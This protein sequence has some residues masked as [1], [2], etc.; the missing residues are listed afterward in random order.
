MI[1]KTPDII[2]F[3]TKLLTL[4]LSPMQA[5]ILASAYGLPPGSDQLELF[6]QG[7]GLPADKWPTTPISTL[8]VI[9]GRGSGK[10]SRIAT[11]ITLYEALF[12]HHE[13]GVIGDQPATCVLVSQN[14]RA[15]K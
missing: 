7:T 9:A 3:A 8:V 12:G 4:K 6:H 14:E 13:P 10:D 5:T 2:A 11:V 15:V 1:P